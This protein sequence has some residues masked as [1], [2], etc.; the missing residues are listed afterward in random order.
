MLDIAFVYVCGGIQL[1]S[2]FPLNHLFLSLM[3]DLH[4]FQ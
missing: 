4:L 2:I 1:N 3:Y